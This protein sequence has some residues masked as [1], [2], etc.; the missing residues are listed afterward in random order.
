VTQLT[1]NPLSSKPLDAGETIRSSIRTELQ[2]ARSGFHDLLGSLSGDG[3]RR[4]SLN[5][6]WTNGEIAFH[7]TIGFILLLMLVPLIRL[8]QHMPAWFTRG[9]A[10]TLN[11]GT[12]LFNWVNGLGPRLGGRL[13]TPD[14]LNR[15]F[16]AVYARLVRMVERV[17][18]DEW[19]F[20]MYYPY[21][22][23]SMFEEYMT[24]E[25]LFRYMVRHFE[26]HL[27]QIAR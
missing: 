7:M 5:P 25:S 10:G 27:G 13:H 15:Q 16:E 1:A 24:I 14:S 9:F 3:W 6:G 11:A 2:T 17:G 12:G 26:F 18:E 22:W 21:K 20:G 4:Q 8:W 19:Q 23:D